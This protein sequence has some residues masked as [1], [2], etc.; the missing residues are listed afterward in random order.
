MK[1]QRGAALIV[2]LLL[3]V[4]LTQLGLTAYKSIKTGERMAGNA[5]DRQ[6]GFQAAEAALREAELYLESPSLPPFDGNNGLYAYGDA[7]PSCDAF[8]A[9]NSRGYARDLVTVASTPRYVIERMKPGVVEGESVV[10]GTRYGTSERTIFRITATGYGGSDTTR[11]S[12]Q[13]TFKR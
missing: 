2:T 12:L 9:A 13:S 7:V 11:V 3:L 4:L 8:T 5:Q 6:L 1:Q 10:S